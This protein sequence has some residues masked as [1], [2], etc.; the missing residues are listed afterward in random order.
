VADA[1]LAYEEYKDIHAFNAENAA[2]DQ[3]S[4][5]MHQ[6]DQALLAHPRPRPWPLAGRSCK[7]SNSSDEVCTLDAGGDFYD[8]SLDP[9]HHLCSY[10]CS[11]G[12]SMTIL[13]LGTCPKELPKTRFD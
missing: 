11:D 1:A 9:L 13:S 10:H 12:S 2:Y 3:E 4:Q 8:P 5:A 6:M 7:Q